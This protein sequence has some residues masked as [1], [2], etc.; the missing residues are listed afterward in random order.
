MNKRMGN[1]A[2]SICAAVGSVILLCSLLVGCKDDSFSKADKQ[3]GPHHNKPCHAH[4]V[5]THHDIEHRH[6]HVNPS[7][8]PAHHRTNHHRPDG[9]HTTV[10]AHDHP[11][12]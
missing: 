6:V 3:C 1:V 7:A 11:A 4:V 5:I 2:A 12:G 8:Q 10:A 9:S